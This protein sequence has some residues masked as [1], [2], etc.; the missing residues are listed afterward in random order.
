MHDFSP[1]IRAYKMRPEIRDSK[2]YDRTATYHPGYDKKVVAD[3]SY[4]NHNIESDVDKNARAA[5]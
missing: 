3:V 1:Q 4:D 2:E 5:V